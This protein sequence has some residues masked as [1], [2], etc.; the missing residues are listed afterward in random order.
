MSSDYDYED[1][2]YS[3]NND[4]N[5]S[6]ERPEQEIEMENLFYQ[7][8]DEKNTN[9]EASKQNYLKVIEIEESYRADKLPGQQEFIFPSLRNVIILLCKLQQT[10]KLESQV[11]KILK[12]MG[13]VARNDATDAINDF[14]ECL[15]QLEDKT[16]MRKV[17][18]Q[19]LDYLKNNNMDQLLNKALFKLA[20]IYFDFKDL[21]SVSKTLQE[22]FK[23]NRNKDGTD[24]VK[25]SATLLECYALEIQLCVQKNIQIKKILKRVQILRTMDKNSITDNRIMGIIQENTGKMYMKQR[26]YLDANQEFQDAFKAYQEVGNIKAKQ[27]LKY[28]CFAS[29]LSKQQIDPFAEQATYVYNQDPEIQAMKNL[30]EAYQNDQNPNIRQFKSILDKK[31]NHIQDDDFL[32][33]YTGELKKTMSLK[34]IITIISGYSKIKIQYL[35]QQLLCKECE[36]ER[37]LME[38]I[39]SKQI[40]GFIN[41]VEGVFENNQI[42]QNDNEDNKIKNISNWINT[43]KRFN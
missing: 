40:N 14:I 22:L 4:S 36:V 20:Y 3:D 30:R 15:I 38:L 19:I 28:W 43:I 41:Q 9:P 7:A 35:A 12:Y 24:D 8:D 37:F 32:K 10:Q 18:E 26:K 13:S 6:Q 17:L 39:L 29:I 31:E 16:V 2:D 11:Q 1:D 27:V 34:K 42:S 5:G 23:L 33:E 25:K 21:E